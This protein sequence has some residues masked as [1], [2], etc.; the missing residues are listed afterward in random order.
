[1]SIETGSTAASYKPL[2]A[3]DHRG[4]K[5]VGKVDTPADASSN[6]SM[7]MGMLAAADDTASSTA[8]L[9]DA[10]MGA[11][12]NVPVDLATVGNNMPAAQSGYA[13][14]AI[15]FKSIESAVDPALEA[16]AASSGNVGS[17]TLDAK[18][19][20]QAANARVLSQT[21]ATTATQVSDLKGNMPVAQSVT[22]LEATNLKALLTP[23][24]AS[25]MPLGRA[26]V[27]VQGVSSV[28]LGAQASD[29]EEKMPVAQSASALAATNLQALLMPQDASAMPL[30]RASVGVQGV[31][32]ASLGA[33]AS[34][35]EEK[36]PV[37]QS[38]SALAA[39]N[40]QALLVPQDASAMPLGRASV[41]VQGVSSASLG[42]QASNLEVKM[43]V[44]QSA[45]ALAATN[46][47]ALL[48]QREVGR[49][50]TVASL[51]S[52]EGVVQELGG[53]SR[54]S[55]SGPAPV[56]AALGTARMALADDVGV[57]IAGAAVGQSDVASSVAVPPELRS[58]TQS[59]ASTQN[60]S[61]VQA[62]LKEARMHVSTLDM[63]ARSDVGSSLSLLSGAADSLL[64]TQEPLA[65]KSSAA[66]FG[67]ASAGVFGVAS[68][69]STRADAPYEIETTAAA[70]PDTAIA[71]TVSYWVTQGVQNAELTLEGFG[72]DPVEVSISLNGD[73]AQ[74]DFRTDQADVRQ[75]LEAATAELRDALSG[76]GLQLAGV[77]VGASGGRNAQGDAQQSGPGVRQG[78]LT[79]E[80]SAAA[81]PRS[82]PSSN[83]SVGRSLDLFV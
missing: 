13:L 78:V 48:V 45:S 24:D 65:A 51:V 31:S 10:A 82:A 40:L 46:L 17:S 57:A 33:Q 39:T 53:G 63:A 26:S 29:L 12:G 44:A 59:A 73:Q 41:G 4:G 14:E 8:P 1:M 83:P 15:K 5:K 69:V 61:V 27:G 64:R 36:M 3:V 77:S 70:V 32:S 54:G 75:A 74:I 60:L 28:S 18:S 50:P 2:G 72:N 37:A 79:Q 49:G 71:E 20:F 34:D 43:P 16:L 7:L 23:Q 52:P 21:S 58:S 30:G 19:G 62:D 9:A 11:V 6:F 35:L 38:A 80:P 22:V 42:A 68:G 25:A 55:T 47:Q 56:A 66:R 76:E 67:D 81:T